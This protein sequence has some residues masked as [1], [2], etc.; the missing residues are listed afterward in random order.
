[1]NLGTRTHTYGPCHK[2]RPAREGVQD[3][4]VLIMTSNYRAGRA[5]KQVISRVITIPRNV[6]NS[7]IRNRKIKI[8]IPVITDAL[9]PNPCPFCSNYTY[10]IMYNYHM[11]NICRTRV[12]VSLIRIMYDI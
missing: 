1:M 4:A 2:S 5:I 9:P 3:L 8:E 7:H 6:E 10:I 11:F 12:Y